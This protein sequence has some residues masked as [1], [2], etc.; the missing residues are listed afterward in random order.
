MEKRNTSSVKT[1]PMNQQVCS[2][3]SPCCTKT[4]KNMKSKTVLTTPSRVA[5]STISLISYFFGLLT[6]AGST[7]SVA[8]EIMGKSESRFTSRI[9]SG[10]I[11]RYGMNSE[12]RAM[13]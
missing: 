11:G 6:S 1:L 2:T 7:V 8:I 9:W 13:A 3:G 5:M 12:P 10:S 4:A